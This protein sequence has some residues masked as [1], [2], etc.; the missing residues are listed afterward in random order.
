MFKNRAIQ[1]KV[2]KDDK[3]PED[4]KKNDNMTFSEKL[5]IVTVEAEIVAKKVC[6]GVAG[7]ILL[8]TFRQVMIEKAKRG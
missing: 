1:F 4:S 3:S 6:L 2:T 7:Y 8:D 5:A